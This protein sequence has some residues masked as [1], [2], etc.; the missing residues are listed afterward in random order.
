MRQ[1]MRSKQQVVHALGRPG[2]PADS[3]KFGGHQACVI[4]DATARGSG[5][6]LIAP[7]AR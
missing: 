5:A 6:V 1:N 4:G 7:A 2:R 3:L